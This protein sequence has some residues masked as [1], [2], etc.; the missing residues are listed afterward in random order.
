M[1]KKKPKQRPDYKT[2]AYIMLI[3]QAG[4]LVVALCIT[5]IFL[6]PNDFKPTYTKYKDCQKTARQSQPDI[7]ESQ[8]AATC[9]KPD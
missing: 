4:L 3:A 2:L 8:L 5:V 1:S 7:T 9:P 6:G